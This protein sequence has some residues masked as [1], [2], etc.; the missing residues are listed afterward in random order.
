MDEEI[1]RPATGEPEAGAEERGRRVRERPVRERP[2]RERVARERPVRERPVRERPVREN[3]IRLRR[4]RDEEGAEDPV[5][6]DAEGT[7]GEAPAG[8]ST[9]ARLRAAEITMQR[10][11]N[12]LRNFRYKFFALH[13]AVVVKMGLTVCE[14]GDPAGEI[15][16][17]E[18]LR[19]PDAPAR[20]IAFGGMGAGLGLPPKQFFKTFRDSHC[21]VIFVK[22]FRQCWYQ[23]GLLGLSE[24]VPSTAEYLRS[25]I[26]D[27]GKPLITVGAS[28]GAFAAVLFGAL[29]GADRMLAF[30]PQTAITTRAFAK[31]RTEDS[32][33][34]EIDFDSKWTDLEAVLREHPLRGEAEI[35]HAALSHYDAEQANRLGALPGIKLHPL[36]WNGHNT[37]N[38]LKQRNLLDPMITRLITG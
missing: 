11:A 28:S 4:P 31:F 6:P 12:R 18:L 22:D 8:K 32:E 27:D 37:A 36:H 21:E 25:L 13:H 5:A 10:Y 35:V 38:Y 17:V 14:L 24:D 9:A 19:S 30:S 29:L 7:E 15:F 20:V 16:P 26:P 34:E 23:K 3:A 2:V 1:H 33:L